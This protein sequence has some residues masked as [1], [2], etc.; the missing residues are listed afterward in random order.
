MGCMKRSSSRILTTHTGSL[1]RPNDVVELMLAAEA[2]TLQ[3]QT[4]LAERV[5]TATVEI[6]QRQMETGIDVVGDGEVSKPSYS[7]YVKDRLNG[8]EGESVMPM[9]HIRDEQLFP[10]Y[11][12]PGAQNRAGIKFP[13]C[14]GPISVRDREAVKRDVAN[15]RAALSGHQPEDVF[16][17]AVSPGQIAR[18]MANAYYP[19]HEAY[20][21]ALADAMKYEYQTIVDA[22]FVLQLDCP[23]LASGRGNSEF[24]DLSLKDWRKVAFMHV[25]ALNQATAGLPQEQLRLHLCWGNYEGPHIHDVPLKDIIDVALSAN[26]QAISFEAANPRHS[27]EWRLFE[28]VKLPPGKIIMPGVLDS[29]TN[30]IE[31]PELVA[32]RLV[33]YASVVGRENVIA[34][35]DCGFGTF[36]GD[37]RVD[38]EIAWA[39]LAAMVEGAKL[40]TAELWA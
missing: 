23:D 37:S 25:D 7:T 32:Q 4:R 16:M 12:T 27:H 29:C 22:G 21:Y 38:A 31:H 40:A 39:K 15:L 17:T 10:G 18:F 13:A 34:G 8:F 6:V 9:R 11:V 1:P 35:A 33:R 36:V 3:D 26:V 20:V 5:G 24:A 30:Y 28:T 2:G 19:S 14:S